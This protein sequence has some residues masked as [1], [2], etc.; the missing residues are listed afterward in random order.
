MLARVFVAIG[1]L[2]VLALLAALIAPLFIDWT[3]YR[4]GFE[5]EAS[6][7]L[8]RKVTVA[9]SAKARLLPFPSVTFS[10]VRVG[11][12]DTGPAMTAEAFSMDAELA[13]FLSGRAVIFDMRLVK[14]K[15]NVAMDAAG[16]IDWQFGAAAGFDPARV[17]LERLSISDGEITL[18]HGPGERTVSIRGLNAVLSA[19]SLAGP[20]RADG[21]ARFERIEAGFTVASG[22]VGD[23][24]RLGLHLTFAPRHFGFDLESDG[25]VTLEKGA[26]VYAG[27][28]AAARRARTEALRGSDGT[29]IA[30]SGDAGWRAK[31][32]FR[33][34]SRA[35]SAEAVRLESGPA[36]DPYVA[37]G[38][39]RLDIGPTPGF[40]LTVAGQQ[41]RLAE[42]EGG[43]MPLA[44]RLNALAET[45]SDLSRPVIPGTIDVRLP[46][47]VA[48]DTTIGDVVARARTTEAGWRIDHLSARLPGRATLEAKGLLVSGVDPA[49]RGDLT[50]A[51][52]QPSG[53]AAW[54]AR[55][56]DAAIRA[57]PGAGFSAKVDLSRTR[58]VFNGIELRL[59]P[60]AF[61]GSVRHDASTRA[62]SLD[63]AL[64][65]GALD[66]DSLQAFASIFFDNSG[67]SR[68]AGHAVDLK[69]KA[70]PLDTGGLTLAALDL[71]LRQRDGVID[72]DRLL[73]DDGQG[74]HLSAT[75]KAAGLPDAV[76][77]NLEGT[78]SGED[79][80]PLILALADRFDGARGLDDIARRAAQWPPLTAAPT[81]DFIATVADAGGGPGFA[82]SAHGATEGVQFSLT[83]SG[84]LAGLA[85]RFRTLSFE[86]KN[87]D[88][89][90]LAVIAGLPMLP[91]GLLP[92]GRLMVD[93]TGRPDGGFDVD[94]SLAADNAT[95][96]YRGRVGRG[97]GGTALNGQASL[98]AE[99]LAPWLVSAG[100]M[101]PN[102][103]EALPAKLDLTL[104]G[105]GVTLGMLPVAGMFAGQAITGQLRW[106]VK[107]G[108]PHGEGTLALESF[109]LGVALAALFGDAAFSGA[110]AQW[111]D[112]AFATTPLLP[113]TGAFTVEAAAMAVP[114]V[115]PV[116]DA[117][118]GL[119]LLADRIEL[120]ALAGSQAGGRISGT[121]A[122]RNSG[123]D[124]L[125]SADLAID[126]QE[127]AA[128]LPHGGMNG[129]VAMTA[130]LATGGKSA[131]AMV[132]G[133]TGSGAIRT[134]ATTF[135]GMNA[136]AF[137]ALL[138]TGDSIR[139]D[140]DPALVEKQ[141]L[142][143]ARA[144]SSVFAPAEATV[145]IASGV[146]RTSRMIFASP[147]ATL[148]GDARLDVATSAIEAAGDLTY[149]A[150]NEALVG[151]EPIVSYAVNGN[152]DTMAVEA[153]GKAMATWLVQRALEREQARVETMQATLIE[154]QRLRR[155]L[156]YFTWIGDQRA[157]AKAEDEAR[158]KAEEEARQKAEEE[159]RLK[160]EEE[161]RQKAEEEARLK[162][163]EEARLKAEEEARL[164]AED[165]ARRKAEDEAGQ[166][167]GQD[168]PAGPQS[169]SPEVTPSP[170]VVP[171]P[172]AKP[173][174]P[175]KTK[176][177]TA[178]AVVEPVPEPAPTEPQP[179]EAFPPPPK[180]KPLGGLLD[181]FRLKPETP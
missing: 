68:F 16:A 82:L 172:V 174:V 29:T 60:A 181:L 15:V 74:A 175:A 58:Q 180:K 124:G 179:A 11:E 76:K 3:G 59:G 123:G 129:A 97:A 148:T 96:T 127:L 94:A 89:G 27:T 81:I 69:F 153:D 32:R 14:P 147:G 139:P 62:P 39:A 61:A 55:D 167:A 112:D 70:G 12:S 30:A 95:M 51:V 43:A 83:S 4:A 120:S 121:M 166:M 101:L 37:E 98:E 107:D 102:A 25:A 46:A 173:Q 151:A 150:G 18:R 163:E 131:A 149:R 8:G 23:D 90:A 177:A 33:A 170:E 135:A 157:Q 24:G 6:A 99:D 133:L 146:A 164:K 79:M 93:A 34:D 145:S 91:L 108:K 84:D 118:F 154:K 5:R 119:S 1:G 28:F 159:A 160:A 161:A 106:T 21:Q 77:G 42:G 144:G 155:E 109:D 48:G 36:K 134:Q 126:G 54:L 56:V 162:A 80:G 104:G 13:P 35:V 143:I 152:P 176:A 141:I 75:G 50:L 105:D 100:V 31:G 87:D 47:V 17:S 57:L 41:V 86:G 7:I 122:F 116:R 130:T 49:F 78:I 178:K 137:Q 168:A 64:D 20:W 40:S 165:E 169:P 92:G 138:V 52:A 110:L 72:I 111:S 156:R 115:P 19:R 136:N 85:P 63:I 103:I 132:A 88:A 125:F 113:V 140:A 65:G 117:R 67:V 26:P 44:E 66:L 71:A 142:P 10:D 128:W 45:L 22:K 114:G 2:V 9:G 171:V 158:L 53:F 73:I 38:E